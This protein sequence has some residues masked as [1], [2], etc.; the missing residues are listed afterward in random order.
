MRSR[1]N[2][3]LITA[4]SLILI[5]CI[6]FVCVMS[7][8]GWDFTK[9]SGDEYETREYKINEIFNSIKVDVST[10]DIEFVFTDGAEGSVVCY[11]K[12]KIEYSVSQ[13][14]GILSI[15]ENDTRKWYEMFEINI[16]SPKITVYLPDEEY[17]SLEIKGSTGDVI[18]PS[19]VSF[20]SVRIDVTTASVRCSA[21]VSG[22]L[23]IEASTSDIYLEN[24]YFGDVEISVSTGDVYIKK[25]ECEGDL[26]VNLSTGKT[27]LEEVSLSNLIS[28]ASTGDMLLKNVIA[29]DKI[30]IERSTGDVKLEDSDASEIFIKTDTGDVRGTLLSEKVF[31]VD[32]DT[33]ETDIPN[34]SNGGK[35]EIITDTGDI[36]ITIKE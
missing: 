15:E 7:V 9:L 22:N 27:I 28:D 23:D 25:A 20:E 16:G 32:T 34:T 14:E 10:A 4:A 36:K 2:L 30:R 13:K 35:C 24:A 19:G 33:G 6:L 31:F 17:S 12:K 26:S 11:E 18:I 29:K 5:G 21:S 8:L 1:K 3:W